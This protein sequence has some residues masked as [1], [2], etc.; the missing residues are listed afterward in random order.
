MQVAYTGEWLSK[1]SLDVCSGKQGSSEGAHC[2]FLTSH[3]KDHAPLSLHKFLLLSM[4]RHQ[5]VKK[6]LYEVRFNLTHWGGGGAEFSAAL[7]HLQRS[8]DHIRQSLLERFLLTA[9]LCF[10]NTSVKIISAIFAAG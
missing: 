5:N 4:L 7:W 2:L 10:L 6:E 1:G 9:F 8:T 3:T